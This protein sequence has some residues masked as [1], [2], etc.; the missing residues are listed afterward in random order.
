MLLR[1]FLVAVAAAALGCGREDVN[2][3]LRNVAQ[4]RELAA[5]LT[6][7]F[8]MASDAANR[9]VM[10]DT[11]EASIEFAKES[12][13][14]TAAVQKD[15]D[16]L[17]STLKTLGYADEDKLLTDFANSFAEYRRLDENV[18]GLA[19]ENTNLKAQ[20]LAFGPAQDAANAFRDTLKGLTPG[21]PADAWHVEALSANA[22]M[23]V[24]EIQVLQGPHIA[25]ADEAVM[26]KMETQMSTSQTAARKSLDALRP[27]ISAA[28]RQKLDAAASALTRFL[29]L[30]TQ[31]IALS[32]RNTNVH[33]LM[34][35]LDE[36]RKM[37]LA[38]QD[39]LRALQASLS[40]RG[41]SGIRDR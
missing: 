33:S 25:D 29:E 8:T 20:R 23:T 21:N 37:T 38:C 17:R 34:L 22:V 13:E 24:R 36:K 2:V 1:A 40:K 41:Y 26:T 12:R 14:A 9:A 4:A 28:S 31:I 15:V 32:R 30:N 19:V 35:S 7:Q 5:D 27:L 10:A 18:L 6:V 16:A 39:N 3:T 11:D